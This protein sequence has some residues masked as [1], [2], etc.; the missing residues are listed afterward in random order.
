MF[1]RRKTA[2]L[3]LVSIISGIVASRASAQMPDDAFPA[4]PNQ[5]YSA[6]GACTFYSA[7]GEVLMSVDSAEAQKSCSPALAAWVKVTPTS[8]GYREFPRYTS[9]PMQVDAQRMI[10]PIVWDADTI[11]DEYV[12]LDG[13]GASANLLLDPVKIVRVS[14]YDGSVI[15]NQGEDFAVTGRTLTQLSQRVSSTVALVPGKKKD[16]SPNGLVNTAHT[17]WTRVTYV[18]AR[19]VFW[20]QDF[21]NQYFPPR[22][23]HPLPNI[24]RIL[25][26]E[27]RLTIQAVGMGITSG[28]HVSGSTGDEINF[29][30]T[31]PYLRGYCELF[32][33]A[34]QKYGYDVKLYNSSCSGKTIKWAADHIVPLAVPNKP[35]LIILDM[36]LTDMVGETT[37]EQ[38]RLGLQRCI[39]SVR[40]HL[41]RVSFLI[42]ANMIPDTAGAGAPSEGAARM[43]SFLQQIRDFAWKNSTNS[44]NVSMIDVTSLSQAVYERKGARS[45]LANSLHPNDYFTLWIA[46]GI[47]HELTGMVTSVAD[48]R[49]STFHV[50]QRGNTVSITGD[51]PVVS[52]AVT[53]V[54]LRGSVVYRAPLDTSTPEHIITMPL[55]PRGVYAITVE[56]AGKAIAQST[57]LAW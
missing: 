18:V 35:D 23:G 39:D 32:A 4:T 13:V 30:P 37:P 19:D 21:L 57:Y 33:Q 29:P 5:V 14:N 25:Y 6:G 15:Y 56:S 20:E 55:L 11:H 7:T 43:R 48:V 44:S 50:Q 53:V 1:T 40:T 9:K 27:R 46:Q 47:T 22:A 3:C 28:M 36:G 8:A 16:G 51:L 24:E 45:C 31:A 49:R 54:D 52:G 41:P 42:I 38:F 26:G 2:V 10:Q 17:S 34:L 12:L